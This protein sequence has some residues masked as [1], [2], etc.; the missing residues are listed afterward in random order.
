VLFNSYEFLLVFLPAVVA[1]Y[2]LVARISSLAAN[3]FLAAASVFFYA[4]W[5]LDF[6]WILAGSVVVNYAAG[7]RLSRAAAAGRRRKA[8]HAA[9]VVLNQ[10]LRG[11]NN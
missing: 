6:L 5:R 3:G 7:R 8:R 11:Y 4:W 10:L 9:G 1:G 2:F